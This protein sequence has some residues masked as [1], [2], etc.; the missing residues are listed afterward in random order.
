MLVAGQRVADQ[1][2]VRPVGIERA[3]GLVRDLQMV[4]PAAGIEKQRLVR[5]EAGDEARRVV[6]LVVRVGPFCSG[7]RG[8]MGRSD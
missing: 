1:D 8:G 6:G 3:V 4:E 5:P 7:R 2:G